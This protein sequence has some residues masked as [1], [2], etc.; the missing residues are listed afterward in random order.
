MEVEVGFGKL[1][2]A[3]GR[4]DLGLALGDRFGSGT[5]HV[6]VV[7]RFR[8]FE[9]DTGRFYRLLGIEKLLLRSQITGTQ[10]AE[11]INDLLSSVVGDLR[12]L[13]GEDHWSLLFRAGERFEERQ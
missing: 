4:L 1:D 5:D 6:H 7:L 13:N 9:L 11:L 3:L 8:R 12:L 2:E 10:P